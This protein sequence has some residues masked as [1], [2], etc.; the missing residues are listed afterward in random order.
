MRVKSVK[1]REGIE[2]HFDNGTILFE[3]WD[4]RMMW[5]PAPHMIDK[6]HRQMYEDMKNDRSDSRE[7]G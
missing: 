4:G 5:V 2:H 3:Y 6:L 1:M 7:C